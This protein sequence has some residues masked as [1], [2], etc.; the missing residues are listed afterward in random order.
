MLDTWDTDFT[1]EDICPVSGFVY[2]LAGFRLEA[3]D[4]VLRLLG[5]DGRVSDPRDVVDAIMRLNALP[6]GSLDAGE[7]IAIPLE[8]SAAR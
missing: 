7:T 4:L 2:R 1:A 5:I 3:R 6:S 8:Y